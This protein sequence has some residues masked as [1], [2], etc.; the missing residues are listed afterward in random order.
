MKSRDKRK[1]WLWI[2]GIGLLLVLVV[3]AVWTIREGAARALNSQADGEIVTAFVGDLAASATATG[4]VV[5]QRQAAL[6]LSS[7]GTVA[8]VFVA[9]GDVVTAG[10]P[11]LQLE[12]AELERAVLSAQQALTIQEA[13]LTTLLAPPQ[14]AELASAQAAVVTAQAQL[15]G[16]LSGPSEEE[17]AA[18]EANLR[19]AQADVGAAA[20]RLNNLTAA[21][22]PQ[23]LRAAEIE[24]QQAQQAATQAAEQHSTVLVT[25][26]NEWLNEEQLADMELAARTQAQQA[27]ATLAAAQEQYDN[28]RSGNPY[29]QTSAQ[30][31]LASAAAQRDAAQARLE[32][33]RQPPS[34]AD[35][36]SAEANLFQAQATLDRLQRGP[37]ETDVVRLEISV[38]QTELSLQR[39]ERALAQATLTAPFDGVVTAVHVQP[40]E[41]AGGV[42]VDLVDFD[43]L[44]VV[45]DMDELLLTD[46]AVGQTAVVTL[47]AWPDRE[48]A[49][50]IS[51]IAP[52]ATNTGSGLVTYAVYLQ[53]DSFDLP[54]RLGMTAN[55]NLITQQVSQ[56][57]LLPNAAINANR[58]A[59]TY[60]VNKVTR[61]AEGQISTTA[62]PVTIG[63]RDGRYTQI[64]SG[65]QAGD[66]VLIGNRPPRQSFGP[67]NGS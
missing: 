25:E 55:A 53:L 22:D 16:L 31:S 6:S 61:D 15:D 44:E 4:Q 48:L 13:N 42:L 51:T 62:V 11:L 12:T 24:L 43:S 39:A 40:G 46:I 9:A 17:I 10:T 8:E 20:A 35:V 18:A 33:L 56:T 58:A 59:G 27:N 49:A 30:A 23:A 47:E 32:R 1:K 54:L 65:L 2:G 45:L 57:L 34:A 29:D 19:A 64:T 36:A 66:E 3:G 21:A 14:A 28:L 26:P 41:T 38:A 7:S 50:T 52:Q 5:A 60:S 37:A 67:P 63:L